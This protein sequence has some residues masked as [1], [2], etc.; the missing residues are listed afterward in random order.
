MQRR[1][2]LKNIGLSLGAAT[3]TPSIIGMFQSCGS[4]EEWIPFFFT[5]GQ[6]QLIKI[7]V[8]III[9]KTDTPSASEVNVHKFIDKYIVQVMPDENMKITRMSLETIVSELLTIAKSKNITDI[10]QEHIIMLFNK[11]LK[12]DMEEEQAH[13]DAIEEF[14]KAMADG[15]TTTLPS[16]QAI[17]FSCLNMLRQMTIW[18]YKISEQVGENVLAYKPIPG[19]QKGCVNL[20]ETTGGKAWAL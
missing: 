20:Q 15:N 9:P 14:S 5:T 13:N 3:I 10:E 4:K 19:E 17:V 11:S 1:V 16:R 8:D 7:M 18:G 6:G 12:I 2:A